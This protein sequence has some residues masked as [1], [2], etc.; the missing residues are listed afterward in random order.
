[1]TEQP[2]DK[3]KEVIQNAEKHW[4]KISSQNEDIS[5]EGSAGVLA[6]FTLASMCIHGCEIGTE[7]KMLERLKKIIDGVTQEKNKDKLIDKISGEIKSS[8]ES[9][10]D[11][12]KREALKNLQKLFLDEYVL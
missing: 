12:K 3:A 2:N 9:E 11:L 5:I 8:I 7:S 10:N 4:D 1:M 6:P